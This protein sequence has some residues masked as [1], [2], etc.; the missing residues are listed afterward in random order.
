MAARSY[1]LECSQHWA[2]S[3]LT[4]IGRQRYASCCIGAGQS[5]MKEL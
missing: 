4:D 3:N 2:S 1:E 5:L